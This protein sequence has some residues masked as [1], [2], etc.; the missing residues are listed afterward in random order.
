MTVPR[1]SVAQT[2]SARATNTLSGVP[3]T[4][5]WR[6]ADVD[7][8]WSKMSEVAT[9]DPTALNTP[10]GYTAQLQ[11][12]QIQAAMPDIL[13]STGGA[14]PPVYTG[15]PTQG[16]VRNNFWR[17]TAT[18][19]DSDGDGI[20][21]W[22]EFSG[23]T[24]G[25][26]HYSSNPF[27]R[28]TDGDGITD[29]EEWAT[30]TNPNDSNSHPYKVMAITPAVG[31]GGSPLNGAIIFYF[32]AALPPDFTLPPTTNLLWHVSNATTPNG[33]IYPTKTYTL[34]PVAGS[35]TIL[36]GR[37]SVAFLPAQPLLSGL[38]NQDFDFPK[39][40]YLYDVTPTSTGLNSLVP[41]TNLPATLPA[42]T[43]T[44][45][46]ALRG[47]TTTTLTDTIG[48]AV[49][50]TSP[51]WNYVDVDP[52]A[53]PTV[54]WSQ[55]LDPATVNSS[56][57]TLTTTDTSTAVPCTVSFDYGL[58]SFDEWSVTGFVQRWRPKLT[59]KLA[60]NVPLQNDTSYTVT[61]GTGLKNLKGLPLLN[62]Y[63]WSF[64]TR[65][66]PA[67]IVIGAGPYV[68]STTPAAYH[69]NVNASAVNGGLLPLTV[70][71]SEAMDPTTLTPCTVH[72]TEHGSS[73]VQALTLSY[74]PASKTLSIIG[75]SLSNHKRYDLTLDGG[76]IQSASTSGA[77]KPL[78]GDVSFPFSTGLG[79]D[80]DP[81][82]PEGTPEPD[83]NGDP[84]QP[85][86]IILGFETG[87]D[88]AG[89]S[90]TLT[91]KLP[92]GKTQVVTGY[93]QG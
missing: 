76:A 89:S 31:D 92:N 29:A 65:P 19:P 16:G 62:E 3:Y 22:L 24:T 85:E 93:S 35:C 77:A 88:D 74:H 57:I 34:D 53:Q 8:I 38:D 42:P 82:H 75:S 7:M 68:V 55:P 79:D 5:A 71:F 12:T 9:S 37:K 1:D 4:G 46:G 47:F 84:D 20:P 25:G 58:E 49:M 61:L 43:Y 69:Q 52:S 50:K 73:I 80:N 67:P 81:D 41:L 59:L 51:S 18:Y 15:A 28:D 30:G 48:P 32:N 36:P 54:T 33:T 10:L 63:T 39:F 45:S 86:N 78:Q 14:T 2:G 13:A 70:T 90:G 26:I 91:A 66:A 56:Q 6:S 44:Y 87:D 72:L 21:D 40:N 17:I 23:F 11:W 83:G 64:R 60:P 27:T